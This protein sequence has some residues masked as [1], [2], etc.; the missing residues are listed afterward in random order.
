MRASP[1]AC[2]LINSLQQHPRNCE[3]PDRQWDFLC[4]STGAAAVQMV[5]CR[6]AG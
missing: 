5:C 3:V 4:W 6:S 2:L 1:R